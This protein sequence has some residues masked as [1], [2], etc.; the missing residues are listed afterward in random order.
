ML[1]TSRVVVPKDAAASCH[2]PPDPYEDVDRT[3]RVVRVKTLAA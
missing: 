3:M 1:C 2:L